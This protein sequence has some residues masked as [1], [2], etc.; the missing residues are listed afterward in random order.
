[1]HILNIY[2]SEKGSVQFFILSKILKK[3][4]V[5]LMVD[6]EFDEKGKINNNYIIN[7]EIKDTKIKIFKDYDFNHLNFDFKIKKN[8]YEISD[9]SFNF[10]NINFNS[11]KISIIKNNEAHQVIGEIDNKDGFLNDKILHIFSKNYANYLDIKNSKITSNSSF[12]FDITKDFK[13]KKLKT[14]S[15]VK[16]DKLTYLSKSKKI[17]KYLPDYQ[18]KIYLEDS[19]I[20]ISYFKNNYKFEGSAN[21]SLND[22]PDK[23]NFKINK[24]ENLYNFNFDISFDKIKI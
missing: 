11:K 3:G 15:K 22:L 17:K 10:N 13:I 14:H 7:G 6:F 21:Y 16:I 9:A 5:K 19:L 23:L 1:M 4:D 2:Q 18:D 20:E 12:S 24:L 8:N